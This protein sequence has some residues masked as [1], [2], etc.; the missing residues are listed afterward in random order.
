MAER[1]RGKIQLH[2]LETNTALLVNTLKNQWPALIT[3][4]Y[5]ELGN[6][7]PLVG[8]ICLL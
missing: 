6:G 1:G 5:S 7:F 8:H 2:L 3:I 4:S